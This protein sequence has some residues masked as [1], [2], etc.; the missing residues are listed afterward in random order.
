MCSLI[1]AAQWLSG[2]E[3]CAD[4]E[5]FVSGGPTLTLLFQLIR[6]ERIQ[7]HLKAGQGHHR[8][9]R[10]TPFKSLAFRRQVDDSP[11]LNASLVAL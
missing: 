5:S 11:T 2:G 10:E 9:A 7:I 8:P 3:T 4:P 6:G 1:F